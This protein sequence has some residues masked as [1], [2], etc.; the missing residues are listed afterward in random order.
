MRVGID[1]RQISHSKRHGLRTYVENL[2]KALS[3]VDDKNEYILYLDAKDT[4]NLECLGSNFTIKVLPWCIRYASTF[5]NDHCLLPSSLKHDQINVMHYPANAISFLSIKNK[6]KTVITVHDAIPL[7]E[8]RE[9]L[10]KRGIISG[11]LD[12]YNNILIRYNLNKDFTIITVSQRSKEDLIKFTKISPKNV[13]VIYEAAN[14]NFRKVSDKKQ[15]EDIKKNYDLGEKYI[16]G[17]S[18]KNGNRIV[19]SYSILPDD[20]KKKYRVGLICQQFEFSN[21]IQ[22][23]ID[24]NKLENKIICIPPVSEKDLVL[25]YNSASLFV[26]PSFYEGF[27]LPVIEAMQCGCPV[28]CSNRGSLPEVAGNAVVFVEKLD[29]ISLCIKELAEKMEA[30]LIDENLRTDLIIKGF[31]QAKKFSWEKTA[32]ET[33][34]IY[35]KIFRLNK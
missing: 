18:H 21:E 22:R 33:L 31:N 1:A 9:P 16:L 26:F 25:L 13:H 6:S 30:I 34:N 15:I 12:W 7:F 4:F 8:Y 29:N 17:F 5:L 35:E 23:I 28:I 11:F 20:I 3:I 2:V 14:N 27:G 10:S 19:D 32:T 24:K